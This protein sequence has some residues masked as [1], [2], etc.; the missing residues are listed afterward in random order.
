MIFPTICRYPTWTVYGTWPVLS[1]A[2]RCSS[3]SIS[4]P[5]PRESRSK[6]S[7]R[8]GGSVQALSVLASDYGHT[9]EWSAVQQDPVL[10]LEEL[11]TFHSAAAMQ[12]LNMLRKDIMQAT[13]RT[14]TKDVASLNMEN[15]SNFEYTKTVLVRWAAHFRALGQAL[16]TDCPGSPLGAPRTHQIFPSRQGMLSMKRRDLDLLVAEAQVLIELCDSG[17]ATIMGNFSSAESKRTAEESRLV[18][19]LTKLTT[20]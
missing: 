8:P 5:P 12:Y 14:Q 1:S 13:H 2:V 15:I 10:A 6:A 7:R 16:D 11:F 17:K 18:G 19:E 20:A 3:R 4:N 9:L